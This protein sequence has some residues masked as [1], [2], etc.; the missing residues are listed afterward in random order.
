MTTPLRLV[1]RSFLVQGLWNPRDLIGAGFAWAGEPAPEAPSSDDRSVS[2]PSEVSSSDPSA[3]PSL[4][5]NAHPYLTPLALGA[6]FRAEADG[7]QAEDRQRFRDALRAPLGSLGDGIFWA[8]WL[9]GALLLSGVA[10]TF[11]LV[12]PMGAVL[13]FL[14]VYNTAHLWVRGWGARVGLQSGLQVGRVLAE[15]GLRVL[16]HRVRAG[17]VVLAGVLTGALAGV[18]VRA[19]PRTR[20]DTPIEV[21]EAGLAPFALFGLVGVGALTFG[22]GF[23]AGPRLRPSTPALAALAL[24]CLVWGFAVLRASA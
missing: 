5:F 8:G 15:Q 1:V 4:H 6:L 18:L 11:G 9:P 10:L 13:L 22:V 21:L 19:L 2:G 23:F 14:C 20:L 24:L 3:A 16:G 17:A 7:I 12:G